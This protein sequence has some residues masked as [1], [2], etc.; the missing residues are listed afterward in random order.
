M[1]YSHTCPECHFWYQPLGL[2]KNKTKKII[3]P[4]CIAPKIVGCSDIFL[5][6]MYR[7]QIFVFV[8]LTLL[9]FIS[10]QNTGLKWKKYII[11]IQGAFVCSKWKKQKAPKLWKAICPPGLDELSCTFPWTQ[12]LSGNTVS[13]KRHF[14]KWGLQKVSEIKHLSL[15]QSSSV[16]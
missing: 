2:D 11:L 10:L 9:K 1:I 8:F 15:L 13:G 12:C 7:V 6:I 3:T 4:L 16:I 14:L 5:V